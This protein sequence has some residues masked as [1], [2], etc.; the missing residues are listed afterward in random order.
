MYGVTH[1]GAIRSLATAISVLAS[2]LGPVT[3]GT[4]LDHGISIETGCLLFA[5][6][7]T[8]GTL[9]MGIARGVRK[10]DRVSTSHI[11]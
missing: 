5:A 4:L 11:L 6:Y 8:I 3:L 9:L 10:R 2:A 7:G 1:L